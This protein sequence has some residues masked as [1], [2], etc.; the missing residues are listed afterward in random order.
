MLLATWLISQ[1]LALCSLT[2]P[3]LKGLLRLGIVLH[4]DAQN[5][6]PLILYML[7]EGLDRDKLS[8]LLHDGTLAL[9]LQANCGTF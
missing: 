1:P 4:V 8:T 7:G 6:V 5:A 2:L 9:K 3:Q